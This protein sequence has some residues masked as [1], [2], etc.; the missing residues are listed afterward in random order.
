VFQPGETY[1][2]A[3]PKRVSLEAANRPMEALH[4]PSA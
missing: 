2:I 1:W 3:L 4:P